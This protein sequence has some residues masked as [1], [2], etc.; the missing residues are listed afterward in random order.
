MV[1]DNKRPIKQQRSSKTRT[2][3]L[4]LAIALSAP[5]L[6]VHSEG[7][8]TLAPIRKNELPPEVALARKATKSAT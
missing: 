7:S 6:R 3:I 2:F 1:S 8:A 5:M 4:V